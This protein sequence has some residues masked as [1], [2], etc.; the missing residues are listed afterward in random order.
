MGE[1][2]ILGRAIATL[3]D[4]IQ[5]RF[6]SPA[7][8]RQTV[9][10]NVISI[11]TVTQPQGV[12]ENPL[13]G[14]WQLP[15]TQ[16]RHRDHLSAATQQVGHTGLM[17]GAGKTP[18]DAP[19]VPHQKAVEVGPQHG[20]RLLEPAPRLNR[21]HRALRAAE[22]PHPPQLSAHFPAGFIR[23]HAGTGSESVPPA[24]HKSARPSSPHA[25]RLGT[26][27]PGSRAGRRLLPSPPQSCHTADPPLCSVG[28]PAP[29]HAAPVAR[30]R[31]PLRWSL[32]RMTT[33]HPPS[34][35]LTPTHVNAKLDAVHPGWG[36]LGL[37]L[38]NDS[39]LGALAAAM[40]TPLRQ[41]RVHNL[42][43]RS[44]NRASAGATITVSGLASRF[45]WMAFGG[46]PREGSRL[47]LP[48]PQRLLQ[49]M[50]QAFILGL[51]PLNLPLQTS[52]LFR[53]GFLGHAPD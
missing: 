43:H 16:S 24:L 22:D 13:H 52:D 50:P 33:V 21:I 30:P 31:R 39:A 20:G 2:L 17:H 9:P 49:R 32:A 15:R 27:R 53:I 7:G 6:Q 12:L 46:S 28:W 25:P 36:N 42:L 47:S 18:V 5:P 38:G 44:R 23:S 51:Q 34:A 19:S 41:Q 40:R 4:T 1:A 48:G 37:V 10:T 35:A 29:A 45:F 26:V 8:H 3:E 14:A 11:S